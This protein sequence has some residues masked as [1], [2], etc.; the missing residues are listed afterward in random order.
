MSIDKPL[1]FGRV[2]DVLFL[3]LSMADASTIP[4]LCRLNRATYETI[5]SHEMLICTSFLRHHDITPPLDRILTMD[6]ATG[7]RATLSFIN[8]QKFMYRR[9]TARKLASR[10]ARSGW[11]AWWA[12][13]GSGEMDAEAEMFRQRV[14]KGLYVM[15]HMSDIARNIEYT[16]VQPYTLAFSIYR[17]LL[18]SC[19]SRLQFDRSRSSRSWWFPRHMSHIYV[20][21]LRKSQ[22][23][24]VGKQRWK[25]RQKLDLERRVD[26]HIA[27][28]MLR[29]FLETIIFAHSPDDDRSASSVNEDLDVTNWFILRQN[30]HSLSRIFLELP[31]AKCCSIEERARKDKDRD[32][33][34][35]TY[36]EVLK[37][38]WD[39]R[40]GDSSVDCKQ[41]E[42]WLRSSSTETILNDFFGLHAYNLGKEWVRQMRGEGEL[43]F[44]I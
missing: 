2:P 3:I 33:P 16:Q 44:D 35:C 27:L 7:Q 36:S 13:K 37:E 18:F 20:V 39:A 21:L 42:A 32:S 17:V 41:C 8:L 5:K 10:V 1:C 4:T 24:E 29:Q 25:F 6:P 38:Y 22:Q 15:F 14:E 31:D 30:A 11:G 40:R 34:V 28:Q 12:I 26:F 43:L 23:R 9:E 19:L